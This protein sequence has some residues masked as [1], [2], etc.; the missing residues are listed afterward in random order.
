MAGN[1]QV[2]ARRYPYYGRA[3][4]RDDGGKP[5]DNGPETR[6]RQACY[7]VGHQPADALY[8][9]YRGHAHRVAE[10]L[11]YQL[12]PKHINLAFL[13]RKKE[14]DGRFHAVDIDKHEI[15]KEIGHADGGHEIEP[16]VQDAGHRAG[17]KGLDAAD[18]G[19]GKNFDVELGI[20]A[21]FYRTQGIDNDIGVLHKKL[22]FV[23]QHP[24]Q[25]AYR[26]QDHKKRYNKNGHRSPAF[27]PAFLFIQVLHKR[28][29][30]H[31]K[32]HRCQERRKKLYQ[33]EK[34]KNT[35]QQYDGQEEV[36]IDF[37]VGVGGWH[38]IGF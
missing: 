9:S 12:L 13:K 29:G 31:V 27:G 32:H 24:C 23:V 6:L 19:L 30:K 16:L 3:H 38:V 8:H 35:E 18:T 37:M 7:Q 1:N 14:Y 15:K 26:Q 20:N 22:C 11:R 4:H 34:K 33:A 36:F 17:S 5:R 28:P 21:G 2:Y 25:Q 10:G